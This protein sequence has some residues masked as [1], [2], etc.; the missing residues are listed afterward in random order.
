M[1]IDLRRQKKLDGDLNAIQQIE[2]VGQ[3]KNVNGI[4]AHRTQNMFF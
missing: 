3:L 4:Y 1:A 2:F